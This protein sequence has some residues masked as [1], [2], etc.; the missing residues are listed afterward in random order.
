M[1]DGKM[2]DIIKKS[3]QMLAGLLLTAFVAGWGMGALGAPLFLT[4]GAVSIALG[5]L[6]GMVTLCI[7]VFLL[8]MWEGVLQFGRILNTSY[9]RGNTD[10]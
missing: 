10:K 8:G 6:A 1:Q 5:A 9:V 7:L 4:A 3:S 2:P